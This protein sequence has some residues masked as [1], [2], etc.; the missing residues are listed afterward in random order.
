MYPNLEDNTILD[1]RDVVSTSTYDMVPTLLSSSQPS[2]QK[3]KFSR[4]NK[5]GVNVFL[6]IFAIII[7]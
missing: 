4:Q 3:S 5:R 6:S 7:S 2:P 1:D